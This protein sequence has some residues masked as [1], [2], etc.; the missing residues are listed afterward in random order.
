MSPSGSFSLAS[1]STKAGSLKRCTAPFRWHLLTAN[2]RGTFRLMLYHIWQRRGSRLN[3]A[4]PAGPA[5]AIINGEV[6]DLLNDGFQDNNSLYFTL[7]IN[8]D[9]NDADHCLLLKTNFEL[10]S[11]RSLIPSSSRISSGSSYN[12]WYTSYSAGI[13]KRSWCKMPQP[14]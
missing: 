5:R 13:I 12:A 14:R 4:N 10:S 1:V 8:M 9:Y 7:F 2:L 6:E 11:F 3:G